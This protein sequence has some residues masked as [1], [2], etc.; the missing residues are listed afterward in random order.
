MKKEGQNPKPVHKYELKVEH[1]EN[2]EFQV[3]LIAQ[4]SSTISFVMLMS[5]LGY[6]NL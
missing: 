3:E 6:V 1:Y 4:T 5:Y 2:I